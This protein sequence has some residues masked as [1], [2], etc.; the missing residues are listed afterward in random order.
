[1]KERPIPFSSP[2]VR[3]ILEGHKTQTRRMCKKAFDAASV[4][5]DGAGS[6]WI[7]WWPSPVSA[8][9]TT[10]LYPD[11]EGFPCPYGQPGDRLWVRETTWRNGGYVATD[12]SNIAYEGKRPSI[13]MRRCDSRIILEITAVRVERLQD[14]SEAD[15][16]A[17][18]IQGDGIMYYD[19]SPEGTGLPTQTPRS[20]Y[21][22]LWDSI[23]GK[24]FPWASNPWVWVLTFQRVKKV[25]E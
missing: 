18:G 12:K 2:M 10:K 1:M 24:R 21:C 8:A 5:P 17:E 7:A 11:G 22:G 3:A 6:G 15:A 25:S 19:Y 23:N 13:F 14:I 9:E 16:I 20:S 4:H